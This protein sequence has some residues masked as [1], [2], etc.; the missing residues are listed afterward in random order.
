MIDWRPRNTVLQV[1]QLWIICQHFILSIAI[2]ALLR[3]PQQLNSND[4]V[5]GQTAKPRQRLLKIL[6]IR[7]HKLKQ[8]DHFLYTESDTLEPSCAT[9][10]I[11]IHK[12]CSLVRR[13]L[14]HHGR[15]APAPH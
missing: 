8:P 11:R 10:S 4:E 9:I 13:M 7:K 6:Q 2:T 5:R 3:C 1:H 15:S 14:C 12:E